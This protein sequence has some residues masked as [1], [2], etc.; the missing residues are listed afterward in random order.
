MFKE[1]QQCILGF[2]TSVS[3][4]HNNKRTKGSEG[5]VKITLGYSCITCEST[6]YGP[7]ADGGKLKVQTVSPTV[8]VQGAGNH[9]HAATCI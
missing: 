2:V 8:T 3:K 6:E 7:K 5:R 4:T 9:P 1:Q